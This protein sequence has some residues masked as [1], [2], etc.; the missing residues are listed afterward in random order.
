MLESRW[1]KVGRIILRLPGK[2]ILLLLA[3]AIG[4]EAAQYSPEVFVGAHGISEVVR[5]LTY[6]LMGAVIFQWIVIEAPAQQRRRKTYEF[7]R[8]SIQLLLTPGP[9]LLK[10]YQVLAENVPDLS[11]DI[12]DKKSL[13]ELAATA[14]G[15]HPAVFG[16][17]RAG[18]IRTIVD[19]SLPRALAELGPSIA[20][21]DP[22][23]TQA[24]SMF[25]R[26]EGI[27]VLEV[28]LTASGGIN[29][30]RDAYITWSLL[31]SARRLY[32][33]LL[34]VGAYGPDIFEGAVGDPPN[35]HQLTPDVLTRTA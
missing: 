21:L 26:K 10:Q 33:A 4:I 9:G 20:Y 24:L 35:V 15:I 30:A 19:I 13:G 6:A 11:L 34:E 25:P 14:G 31:E 32:T 2:S 1:A 12:W 18:L 23:V 17:H 29:P 22:E 8:Q 3:V 28:E 5:N 7:C 27:S 16:A